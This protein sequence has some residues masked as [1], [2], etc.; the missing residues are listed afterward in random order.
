MSSHVL[1]D[2]LGDREFGGHGYDTP[3]VWVGTDLKWTPEVPED[4]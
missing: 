3:Y 2:I 1:I 4:V